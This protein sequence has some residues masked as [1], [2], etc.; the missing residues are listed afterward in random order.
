MFH[1]GSYRVGMHGFWWLFR[2]LDRDA[3]TKG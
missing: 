3:V 1:D 2:L